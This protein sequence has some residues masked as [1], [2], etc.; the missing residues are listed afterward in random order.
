MY[1]SFN[2]FLDILPALT[3]ARAN[4]NI[5]S[6]CLEVNILGLLSVCCLLKSGIFSAILIDLSGLF[7]H[8]FLI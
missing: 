1:I 5:L 7:H 3:C 4:G 2:K 8:Y 6:I